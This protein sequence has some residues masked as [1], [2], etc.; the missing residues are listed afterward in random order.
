LSNAVSSLVLEARAAAGS[1]VLAAAVLAL[2]IRLDKAIAVRAD[3][4]ETRLLWFEG[5]RPD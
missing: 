4:A 2:S 3:I 1:G 5:A